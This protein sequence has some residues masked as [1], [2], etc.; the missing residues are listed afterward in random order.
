MASEL[1]HLRP[2]VWMWIICSIYKKNI[3]K[4][5]TSSK[6]NITFVNGTLINR[7]LNFKAGRALEKIQSNPHIF[8]EKN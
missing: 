6:F 5:P 8:Q 3:I 1:F 4:L 2:E 7:S